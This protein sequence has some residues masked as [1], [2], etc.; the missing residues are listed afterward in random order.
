[1]GGGQTYLPVITSLFV[2]ER[3]QAAAV[4]E[5]TKEAV[6]IGACY[7]GRTATAIEGEGTERLVRPLLLSGHRLLIDAGHLSIGFAEFG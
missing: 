5:I 4:A 7:E 6:Q 2:T 3:V 1:M